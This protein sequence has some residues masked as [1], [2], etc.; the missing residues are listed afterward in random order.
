MLVG[1]STWTVIGWLVR[2][3]SGWRVDGE[4]SASFLLVSVFW[5]VLP[6]A[7][8]TTRRVYESVEEATEREQRTTPR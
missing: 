6:V 5:S 7:G 4:G 3:R 2:T 8:R 1:R